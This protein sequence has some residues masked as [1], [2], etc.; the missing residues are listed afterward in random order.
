VG[1][2]MAPP[3]FAFL[4]LYFGVELPAGIPL[5]QS[6]LAL[7]GALGLFGLNVAPAKAP[8]ENWYYD[9]YKRPPDGAYPTTNCENA[10]SAVACRAG[11]TITTTDGYV[12]GTRGLLVLSL[13]GPILIIQGRALVLDF[14]GGG[15]PPFEA[16][17]VFD[18]LKRTVQFNVEAQAE[19]VEGV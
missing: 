15:E 7:K 5:G 2:N 12:K 10:R 11:L 16:L 14:L 18:G 17:A 8:D 3:P 19:L 13:P 4:Y 6:G 9:W 1:M